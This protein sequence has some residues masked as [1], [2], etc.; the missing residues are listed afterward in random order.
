MSSI[1]DTLLVTG[2]AFSEVVHKANVHVPARFCGAT[3]NVIPVEFFVIFVHACVGACSR[4]R[5]YW[6]STLII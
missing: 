3:W 2:F 6:S 4:D 5:D 1:P